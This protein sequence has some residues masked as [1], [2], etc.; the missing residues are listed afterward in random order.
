M[1]PD[2]CLTWYSKRDS[3]WKRIFTQIFSH[4][5]QVQG[6]LECV[7]PFGYIY[8]ISWSGK[9]RGQTKDHTWRKHRMEI[10]KNT[11][12]VAENYP[13]CFCRWKSWYNMMHGFIVN[14]NTSKFTYQQYCYFSQWMHHDLLNSARR[15]AKD[16][17]SMPLS[18]LLVIA[19]FGCIHTAFT[20]TGNGS[21][22]IKYMLLN[23]N[24]YLWEINVSNGFH[25]HHIMNESFV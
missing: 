3:C 19:I 7:N 6:M 4:T 23:I 13:N 17:L 24:E 15:S 25:R 2:W 1:S 18:Y 22:K 5:S 10:R 14:S 12:A 21:C 9:D 16:F 8:F 20:K 11:Q